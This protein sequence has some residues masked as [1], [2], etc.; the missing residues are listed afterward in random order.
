MG[1]LLRLGRGEGEGYHAYSIRNERSLGGLLG[2]RRGGEGREEGRKGN[3]AGM[4]CVT[5]EKYK[6]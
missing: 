2:R 4:T 3:G 5:K 6:R 1:G